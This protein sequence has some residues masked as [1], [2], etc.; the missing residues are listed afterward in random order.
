MKV[1]FDKEVKGRAYHYA[2]IGKAK[3]HGPEGVGE[4]GSC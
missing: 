2:V 3:R 1:F 4:T